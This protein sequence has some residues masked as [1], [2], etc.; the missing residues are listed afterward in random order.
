MSILF[1][2]VENEAYLVATIADRKMNAR[3]AISILKL[4]AL[5]CVRHNCSKVL[6][7]ESTLETR[8]IENHEIRSITENMP[9]IHL[10][11]LCKPELIDEKSRLLN[12]L[13]FTDGYIV[14]H[15]SETNEALGWLLSKSKYSGFSRN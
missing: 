12:A 10:A 2:F 8:E 15:F 3:R 13:S 9:D 5:E 11:C 1:E 6:L 7:D 14:R 4:I